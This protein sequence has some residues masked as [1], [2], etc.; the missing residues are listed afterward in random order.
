MGA[1][2]SRKKLQRQ[3]V[4]Q[5]E[6][7]MQLLLDLQRQLGGQ[8]KDQLD[9]V[10][11]I[12][13]DLQANAS[14]DDFNNVSQKE[15]TCSKQT[16]T[17][18]KKNPED[19]INGHDVVSRE[20]EPAAEPC[21]KDLFPLLSF[22]NPHAHPGAGAQQADIDAYSATVHVQRSWTP[23]EF[24]VILKDL[25]H[26]KDNVVHWCAA[27]VDLIEMYAPSAREME[28]IFRKTFGLRWP[29]LRGNFDVN[30]A[31]NNIV[32]GQLQNQDG[33]FA[34]VKAAF[35]MRTDWPRIHN[36][37]QLLDES[38]DAYRN[39]IE[40]C[41]Q[42]HSGVAEENPAYNDLLKTAVING[43]LPPIHDRVMISCIGWE[44]RSL[45]EVWLPWAWFPW[46]S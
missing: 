25:P 37:K 35:P 21:K 14:P 33:L 22:P 41:F 29:H 28:S 23:E 16:V 6:E 12:L 10:M 15:P 2:Q 3:L 1:K 32:T 27:I 24:N 38:C 34:R 11:C 44:A 9:R 39:R 20:E 5:Q 45:T 31:R 43:L 26:P 30:G 17:S 36:T 18:P 19:S 46:A 7:V 13:A 40:D 42:K 8:Q 4:D